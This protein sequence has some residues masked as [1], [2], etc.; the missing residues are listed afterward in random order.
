[1]KNT[2]RAADSIGRLFSSLTGLLFDIP[3][4]AAKFRQVYY[5]CQL[6]QWSDYAD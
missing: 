1:L 4:R 2:S 6:Y 3:G 5:K